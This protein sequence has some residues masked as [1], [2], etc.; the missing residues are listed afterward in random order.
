MDMEGRKT[1][2]KFF[3]LFSPEGKFVGQTSDSFKGKYTQ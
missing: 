1:N 3:Y 2:V